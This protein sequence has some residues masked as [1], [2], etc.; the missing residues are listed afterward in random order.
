MT[1]N[2]PDILARIVDYKRA[3]LAASVM[4]RGELESLAGENRA[5][6]RNFTAALLGRTPAI[7]AEI[8]KASPSKGV[9]V[10]H[11]FDPGAIAGE[12]EAGGAA[13]L[14]VV[15]DEKFF[16]GSFDDLDIARGA[17]RLPVLRKD[18]IFDE[19]HVA[20]SAARCADAILLLAAILPAQRLRQLREYAGRFGLAALVEVHDETEL[21]AALESGAQLIGV[22]N[23]N[24]RT[25]EVNLENSLR[26]AERIP[27]GIVK[28]SESGIRCSEDICRL[29]A[30]GF[31]AFLVGEH[32][33]R[34]KDRRHA[35]QNL[36]PGVGP[37]PKPAAP[38]KQ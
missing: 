22:N 7:I 32:L 34:S 12:Y 13:A 5:F 31:Q 9:L 29:Q 11:D 3:E 20:E 4:T 23:R 8:K 17:V 35:L 6:R 21:A 18:F 38:P 33:M 24:L 28:V 2:V 27:D 14:S 1:G 36:F 19:F 15:T 37:K 26:L 10:A 25:F 30:A 16:Q